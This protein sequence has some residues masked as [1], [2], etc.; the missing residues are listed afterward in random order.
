M[1]LCELCGK[2]FA[3]KQSLNR[4]RRNHNEKSVKNIVPKS[5][6]HKKT[7]RVSKKQLNEFSQIENFIKKFDGV[8]I[9]EAAF[10]K[11]II[12]FK[13]NVKQ[14]ITSENAIQTY[15]TNLEGTI[16]ELLLYELEIH[17]AVKFQ[18][19]VD[20]QY[21]KVENNESVETNFY[22]VTK[23]TGFYAGSK[24]EFG[25][26]LNIQIKDCVKKADEFQ[27]HSSGWVFK[28]I[29]SVVIKIAKYNAI[30]A[31]SYIET[32]SDIARK[33][34]IVNIKNVDQMCFLYCI[35]AHHFKL[36][37]NTRNLDRVSKY[38]Q[39]EKIC[40]DLNIDVSSLK[41]PVKID[42]IRKFELK[43]ANI[44]INVFGLKKSIKKFPRKKMKRKKSVIHKIVG[45][46][47][48]TKE[49]KQV[50]INLLLL[51][52]DGNFHYCLITNFSR[53]VSSQMS[54]N[55]HKKYFCDGCITPYTSISS[56]E[57]HQKNGCF[58]AL[59]K[60]PIKKPFIEFEAY[61]KTMIHPFICV[62]DFECIL[63]PISETIG[64]KT[65]ALQLHVPCSFAFKIITTVP[66]KDDHL[67]AM[68]I[69]SGTDCAAKFLEMLRNDCVHIFENYY[70]QIVPLQ[71]SERQEKVFK[72][73]EHCHICKKE[74][75]FSSLDEK[76]RKVRDH[77][78]ITGAFR[79]ASHSKCNLRYQLKKF[80]PVFLHNLSR[81]DA[82]L[83]I[84]EMSRY[85]DDAIKV[86]GL[87]HE[88]Y[89]SFS[90]S[91]QVNKEE[92]QY[93]K[94][95]PEYK[96]IK[97]EIRFVDSF[98]FLTSS[99][100]KIVKTIPKEN[101]INTRNEF[102][103]DKSFD[104]MSQKGHVCF[105]Y[106]DSFEKL[107]ERQLPGIEE[108]KSLLTGSNI[109]EETYKHVQEVYTHFKCEKILDY[110]MI[111]LKSD[112]TLLCDIISNFRSLILNEYGLDIAH[113]YTL[114]GLSW[115]SMLKF[116]RE[117]IGL[118]TDMDQLVM[119]NN[120]IRG[121][122]V[123][124][125]LKYCESNNKYMGD[126]YDEKIE[127][128][129]LLYLD[130]NN[131]YGEALS[132]SLPLRNFQWMDL[133]AMKD[134]NVMNIPDDGNV[135]FI[136]DVDLEYPS[137]LHEV[138]FIIS[139]ILQFHL[140]FSNLKQDHNDLPWCPETRRMADGISRLVLTLEAKKNYV[141]HYRMLKGCLRNGLKLVKINRILQFDQKPFIK[142]FIDKN[143]FLRTKAVSDF[144][145]NTW[146]LYNNAVYGTFAY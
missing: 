8:S 11:K 118:I 136:C 12:A 103:D 41:Y 115:Q 105:D 20:L 79:G 29:Q 13:I 138:I 22:V 116:S 52:E 61:E 125:V 94:E 86:I 54:K 98:R 85:E 71:M 67:K 129:Y 133:D 69:Y 76:D 6:P 32:P 56:L 141:V 93:R 37:R 33:K 111:Y 90:Q 55:E 146:K 15:L 112:I 137:A 4:H 100:D 77:D 47:H 24:S 81:Y 26:I 113:F 75:D 121:G 134:F 127:D 57:E 16:L 73:S 145:K 107:Y 109:S 19:V 5:S 60:L 63:Q 21:E 48:H 96:K 51:E 130:K 35:L 128:S 87:T 30:R 3:H 102:K 50:H 64:C 123:Q 68:R 124:S 45:P 65:T 43:N 14:D 108:F 72:Y 135:G 142:G 97:F 31:S 95:Q 9:Y 74:F 17:G 28:S 59:I 140:I 39:H 44:S 143:T 82:S 80:L 99:I 40:Q 25:E 110:L 42:E 101:L 66:L 132:S 89:I 120:G 7:K 126:L 36:K 10:R 106:I 114:P 58:K 49:R 46:F 122:I 119:V 38:N 18:L 27:R 53:L 104:L 1:I 88:N 84:N 34:A 144:E 70:K 78:H 2:I 139:N 92:E 117:K 83:F 23:F 131:L 91:F 62:A